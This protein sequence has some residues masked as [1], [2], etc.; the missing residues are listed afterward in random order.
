MFSKNRD[1]LLTAEIAQAFLAALL[2]D[3][4]VKHLLSHEHFSVEGTLL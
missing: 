2:V 1:R 4:K 3:P